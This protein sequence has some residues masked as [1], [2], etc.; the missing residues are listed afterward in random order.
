MAV[1]KIPSRI[2]ELNVFVSG[3]GFL[4][5]IESY[6]L[7]TVKTKKDVVNGIHVDSG[8]LEPM[9]FEADLNIANSAIFNEANKMKDAQFNLKGEYLEDATTK[10]IVA[11]IGG[12]IDAEMDTLKAGDNMKTKVKMY[13]NMYV[14]TLDGEEVYNVDLP[15]LIAKIGGKDIYESTRS[16]VM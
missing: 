11:T 7:P 2:K 8:L 3:V 9:E 6:K 13:V 1:R 15:N 14:L 10:K 4:G 16:A 5:T 12:S